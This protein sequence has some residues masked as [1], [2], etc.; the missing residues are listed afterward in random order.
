MV[1]GVTLVVVTVGLVLM[2]VVV[3]SLGGRGVTTTS[4]GRG[5]PVFPPVGLVVVEVVVAEELALG[6]KGVTTTSDGRG[7]PVSPPD[8]AGLGLLDPEVI[9]FVILWNVFLISSLSWALML[10][11]VC[12]M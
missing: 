5:P 1:L 8:T 6:G 10:I 11:I 4:D 3:L 7:P 9:N 2:V 12:L